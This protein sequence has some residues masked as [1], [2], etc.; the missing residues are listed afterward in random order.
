MQNNPE[1]KP[2]PFKKFLRDKGYYMVLILCVVAV[3]VSGYLFVRTA[4]DTNEL[5]T[6]ENPSLSVPLTPSDTTPDAQIS[7]PGN[8]TKPSVT[9]MDASTAETAAPAEEQTE[10]P[11]SAPA[12]VETVR[13]CMGE[14]LDVFSIDA[15]VYNDTTR[16]WRTHDGIDIAATIGDDV[17]CARKGQVSEVFADNSLGQVVVVSHAD[18]YT[19]WYANLAE[20]VAVTVG[21]SVDAG[22]LL[23]TIGT[24]AACE[25]AEDAHL[26]FAVYH[27]DEAVSPDAF[28]G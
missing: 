1:K 6:G 9:D 19:T 7:K 22:E 18:G 8:P 25:L 21:Q 3:G 12:A 23:G 20:D 14:T 28:L 15:L 13:P 11:V 24:S 5:G 4:N 27:N 17:V 10:T 2:S 16:D 26:H